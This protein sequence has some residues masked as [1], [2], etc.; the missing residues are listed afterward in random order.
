MWIKNHRNGTTGM[1]I[2]HN[3]FYARSYAKYAGA[4][5]VKFAVCKFTVRVLLVMRRPSLT[6]C[7]DIVDYTDYLGAKPADLTTKVSHKHSAFAFGL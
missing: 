1:D 6:G 4:A 2:I 5:G 7:V 3:A